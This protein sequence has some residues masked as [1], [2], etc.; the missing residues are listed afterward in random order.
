MVL[1]RNAALTGG[2]MLAIAAA[3]V[4]VTGCQ[5]GSR[6]PTVTVAAVGP[7]APV[8]LIGHGSIDGKPWRFRLMP[9]AAWRGTIIQCG[10]T[11]RFAED[12]AAGSTYVWSDKWPDSRPL[13][14]ETQTGQTIYGQVRPAVTWVSARLS[15]GAVLG[16]RPVGAYGRRWIALVVPD[17]LS[18]SELIVY[19]ARGEIAHSVPFLYGSNREPHFYT[20]LPPGDPGPARSTR[21][22]NSS[23]VPGQWLHVGPWGTCFM[24]N[25]DS[26]MC[27]PVDQPT[28]GVIEDYPGHPATS[29]ITVITYRPDVAYLVLTMSNGTTERV[30]VVRGAGMVFAAFKITRHPAI[31]SWGAYD[32]A[33]RRVSGGPGPPDSSVCAPPYTDCGHVF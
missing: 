16:L 28:F 9:S 1:G 32:S 13:F 12:C 29:R 20:W 4:L 6:P 8:G 21:L 14:L 25:S 33:R 22:L 15:D 2:L 24:E 27:W 19:S 5:P 30:P 31:V 7:D 23:V 18:V 11:A 10:P 17:Q 3:T 26:G